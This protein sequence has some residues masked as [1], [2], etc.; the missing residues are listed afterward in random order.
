MA[1]TVTNIQVKVRW[2]SRD[3]SFSL[4]DTTGLSLTNSMY[5]RLS[6]IIPWPELNRTNTSATTT[7]DQESVTWPA[8]KFL[9]VASVEMQDPNDNLNYITVVPA[10]TEQEWSL[11]RE[12]ENSF[13]K[14]YKRGYDGTQN[15]IQ[16]A[17]TPDTGSLIVRITGQLEPTEFTAGSDTTIFIGNTA[18]DILAFMIAA[19]IMDKR[20]QPARAK[21]LIGRAAELLSSIAGR[22]ITPAELKS[23]VESG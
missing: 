13:P 12:E 6:A 14:I 9:D 19:D 3:S 21:S 23:E 1:D 17:P 5:R 20:N 16:F 15:V 18:D 2:E 8:V 7:A 22:E 11:S 10:R 4:T